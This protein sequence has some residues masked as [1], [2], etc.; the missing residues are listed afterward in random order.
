MAQKRPKPTKNLT[1][2]IRTATGTVPPSHGPAGVQIS[3][4]NQP[5]RSITIAEWRMAIDSAQSTRLPRRRPLLDIFKNV[6]F[7]GHWE[8]VSEK[9]KLS[10][11][12]Q[13]VQFTTKNSKGEQD[14][15]V[16]DQILDQ[17]WFSTFLDA[18][19]SS[20][21]YGYSL[22]ELVPG[23]GGLIKKADDLDRRNVLIDYGFLAWNYTTHEPTMGHGIYYQEDPELSNYLIE[24]KSRYPLG[25]LATA[26]MLIILKRG[27]V[28]DWAEFCQIVGIPPKIGKYT[29]YDDYS[30]K[31]LEEALS[32]MGSNGYIVI[33][34]GSTVEFAKT[35]TTG[36]STS[37]FETLAKFCNEELS[38]LYLGQTMTTDNG[39]SKSQG[40][41]HKEVEEMIN[42]ADMIWVEHI[43]NGEFREKLVRLGYRIPEG[44]FHF[45]ETSSMSLTDRIKI[46][47]ELDKV[48][49][50]SEEYWYTTYG[51]PKP[52]TAEAEAWKERKN[53]IP[54]AAPVPGKEAEEPEPA[55]APAT[56]PKP[57]NNPT[58]ELNTQVMA[59]YKIKDPSSRATWPVAAKSK[60]LDAIW[61]RIVRAIYDGEIKPGSIDPELM[62]WIKAEL[63]EAITKGMGDKYTLELYQNF[64]NKVTQDVHVFSGFKTYQQLR[65]VTD[66]LKDAQGQLRPF[67][68]FKELVQSINETYNV[69]Y[70]EAEYRQAVAASQMGAKWVEMYDQRESL[71]MLRFETA[72]D[73]RVRDEHARLDGITLPIDDSF[74]DRY[75]P[76][77]DW[78]CRCDVTPQ[79]T[80]AERTVLPSKLPEL[81]DQF[82]VNWGKKGILF[83][84]NHPYY[85]VR[86]EDKDKMD[87]FTGR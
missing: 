19:M 32:K 15:T 42:L 83:P 31:K 68:E 57:A 40:E 36:Q 81:K 62:N 28:A 63:T 74:W 80:S 41:V 54:A 78:G 18:V 52:T 6:Q 9:R 7:D 55:P 51:I 76:P 13:K 69:T 60:D 44:R 16:K 47:L 77:L 84:E 12:T 43:L 5:Q 61:E 14:E 8:A 73:E 53:P 4:S 82:A 20:I 29:P 24:V 87:E 33:P 65:Q 39:S 72:G 27:S 3:V 48:V 26:A 50:I 38:K 79:L 10:I 64:L 59:L 49:P 21:D 30:R 2:V 71:G 86:P 23:E 75:Y 35:N 46:D 37:V 17:A 1:R 58:G 45:P 85:K 34:E 67:A 25:K 70:L 66:M 56:K 22:V 11:T